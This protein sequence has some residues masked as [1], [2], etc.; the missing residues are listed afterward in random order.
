MSRDMFRQNRQLTE[1]Y[2]TTSSFG[3]HQLFTIAGGSQTEQ[4]QGTRT[5]GRRPPYPLVSYVETITDVSTSINHAATSIFGF[6]L[7]R[8]KIP[9]AVN[10]A[11]FLERFHHFGTWSAVSSPGIVWEDGRY[12]DGY[13]RLWD[14]ESY[15]TIPA[16]LTGAWPASRHV[17]SHP[18]VA[19]ID[20]MAGVSVQE[21]NGYGL[22][23]SSGALADPHG[24]FNVGV[25]SAGSARMHQYKLVAERVAATLSASLVSPDWMDREYAYPYIELLQQS[26]NEMV[27]YSSRHALTIV[28]KWDH[29][30][31]YKYTDWFGTVDWRKYYPAETLVTSSATYQRYGDEDRVHVPA[32]YPE[33]AAYYNATLYDWTNTSPTFKLLAPHPL[34]TAIRP[35][36]FHAV[37][38][39]NLSPGYTHYQKIE[40][41]TRLDVTVPLDDS[42]Y[43][44]GGYMYG[45]ALSLCDIYSR[46]LNRDL[47]VMRDYESRSG[48][49][50]VFYIDSTP[51]IPTPLINNGPFDKQAV[52]VEEALVFWYPD[53]G[54]SFSE[55]G[56][57]GIIEFPCSANFDIEGIGFVE[58]YNPTATLES[59]FSGVTGNYAISAAGAIFRNVI[60]FDYIREKNR[61]LIAA[62]VSD[63]P[64]HREYGG[65]IDIWDPDYLANDIVSR[66]R[67][68]FGLSL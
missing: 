21:E 32:N 30:R 44:W 38:Y 17:A 48:T 35:S 20:L 19:Y 14:G 22:A 27:W 47:E 11:Q 2:T 57:V 58:L 1:S 31:P 15:V 49:K 9:V 66:I 67:S 59:L 13:A 62:A 43:F 28:L 63:H 33:I 61:E 29:P 8:S 16:T 26:G 52:D 51:P 55:S 60:S 37:I 34:S 10:Y 7:S 64:S 5:Q 6:P 39:S 42:T 36:T 54:V 68:H 53:G 3:T 24:L 56:G 25:G 41:G 23:R 4:Y 40:A 18:R 12:I 45:R 50:H 65:E 46:R